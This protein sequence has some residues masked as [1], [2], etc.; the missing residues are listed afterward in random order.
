MAKG[1]NMYGTKNFFYHREPDFGNHTS[2]I[3]K[4]NGILHYMQPFLITCL[5]KWR[6]I[7]FN[8]V[9]PANGPHRS[10]K[11]RNYPLLAEF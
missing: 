3:Y 9:P 2:E 10:R 6:T 4:V 11:Q 1:T 8:S 5:R 7:K